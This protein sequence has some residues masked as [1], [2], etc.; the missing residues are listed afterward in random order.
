MPLWSIDQIAGTGFPACGIREVK[1]FSQAESPCRLEPAGHMPVPLQLAVQADLCIK[2]WRDAHA[3]SN[4]DFTSSYTPWLRNQH[5]HRASEVNSDRRKVKGEGRR[6]ENGW[7]LSFSFFPAP[8]SNGCIIWCGPKL[9]LLRT[10][11]PIQGF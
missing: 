3:T 10:R 1:P 11:S 9:D 8:F 4:S 5:E 2:L 7:S 6:T